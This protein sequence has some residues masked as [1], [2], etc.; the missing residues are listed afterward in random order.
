MNI[1]AL[2]RLIE[3]SDVSAFR[4]LVAIFLPMINV[5][6][7]DYCDGPY[8][9]GKDFNLLK[10]PGNGIEIGIQISVEKEWQKKINSD[11]A[12]LKRN[13]ES[14]VMYFISSRRIPEGSFDKIREDVMKNQGVSVIKYDCQ[15]IAKR[16]IDNDKVSYALGLLGIDIGA[17]T[18][19]SEKYLSSKNEAVSSLLMFDKNSKDLRERFFQ[20]ILKSHLSRKEKCNR[21]ELI[22]EVKVHYQLEEAQT[23]KLNSSIDR[24]LQ[25]GEI[26]SSKSELRLSE[27]E[28]KRFSGLR[29][30]TQLE[31]ALLKNEFNE[32]ISLICPDLDDKTK[33]F[34]LE[35]FLD[36]TIYLA[37]KDYSTYDRDTKDNVAYMSI[38]GIVISRFGEDKAQEI[39]SDLAKFFSEREFTKHIACSKLYEAFLNTSSSQL[40]NALGGTQNLNIYIDSSVFIPIICGL[41]YENVSNRFSQSGASLYKLISDHSF[42]AILPYEYVEEVASH[43]IEAC[44]D[45]KHIIESDIDLSFSGNAFVSHYSTLRRNGENMSFE[46]Y[47]R[48]FGIRLNVISND[49]SDSAF[50]SIRDRVASEIIKISAKYGFATEELRVE[51]LEKKVDA[52]KDFMFTKNITRPDV[53]VRHDAKVIAYLSGDYVPSG[54]V[55]VLCT[56]DKIHSMKNPDGADGY[57][58]MHPI[59]I[60]DYLSLAKGNNSSYGVSHLLDFASLQSESDL[61]LSSKI[62]D[63][64]AK[65][66][67]DNLSDAQ[68]MLKAREFQDAY[69]L[70]HAND[71]SVIDDNIEREWMAW[72]Q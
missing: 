42:N 29:E 7:A 56:W 34:L 20:S 38:K 18:S 46:D 1:E 67:K 48:I 9:G 59:S 17:R 10:M 44:R 57:Y 37:S 31:L 60:I 27:T 19:V 64:I 28:S 36:L 22:K 58:V 13:F 68:V 71:E 40:I 51:Y 26:L 65:V 43:L 5:N 49:M 12:K 8:D 54:F 11:A 4:S 52:L 45:Y 25:S 35:N 66:E 53:L 39:F 41:L 50:W 3:A 2:S 24:L 33:N 47:V 21:Q 23:V 62:W 30:T 14:N 63:S 72:K 55:K 15:S 6:E 32:K 61:E 69:T 70:K 16:I